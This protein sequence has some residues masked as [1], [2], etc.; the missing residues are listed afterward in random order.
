MKLH[1]GELDIAS[2]LGEG[3]TVTLSFPEDC[4]IRGGDAREEV[5][6][7]ARMRAR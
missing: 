2:T 4:I 6:P 7:R 1:G 5:E 3:T